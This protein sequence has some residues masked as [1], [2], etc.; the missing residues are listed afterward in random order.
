MRLLAVATAIAALLACDPGT[1]PNSVVTASDIQDGDLVITEFIA[2]AIDEL[3]LDDQGE[4]VEI[5]NDSPNT[6]DTNGVRLEDHSGNRTVLPTMLLGPG[7]Y[8]LFGKGQ[9]ANWCESEAYPDA[10]YAS[11]FFIN[12][13]GDE[14]LALLRPD[15]SVIDATPVFVDLGTVQGS[16]AL[17]A[18]FLSSAESDD[19]GNWYYSNTCTPTEPLGSPG[20]SNWICTAP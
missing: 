13:Y 1:N 15:F 2:D 16:V 5:Y 4:W 18:R 19:G 11:S 17:D 6:I 10:F 7:E 12:N 14:S 9:A 20:F 3:C 8:G